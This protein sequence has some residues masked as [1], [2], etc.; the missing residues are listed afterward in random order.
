MGL[1]HHEWMLSILS[2]PLNGLAEVLTTETIVVLGAHWECINRQ[3]EYEAGLQP[4][5]MRLSSDIY[6]QLVHGNIGEK[7]LISVSR[8]D[9]CQDRTIGCIRLLPRSINP[10]ECEKGSEY[11]T[12][13]TPPPILVELQ[14]SS[15][16]P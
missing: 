13:I 9:D 4:K 5:G 10:L 16:N 1:T 12:W 7:R 6:N 11:L 2:I 3:P 14:K 8:G 15:L